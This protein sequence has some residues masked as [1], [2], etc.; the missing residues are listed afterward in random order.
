M[1]RLVGTRFEVDDFAV[2]AERIEAYA[3]ATGD[4][5]PAY[6]GPE[7]VAPPVFGIVPVWGG[8]QSAMADPRLEIDLG[9]IVHGEQHMRYRRPI[10]A[11][12]VL[13]ST[14][15]LI[16]VHERGENEILVLRFSTADA[17]GEPV[18]EQD[19]VTVSRGTASGE[20]GRSTGATP[21]PQLPSPPDGDPD[22]ARTA[23]LDDEITYRYAKASGDDNRIHVDPEFARGAGLPGIIVQ[24]L[25]LLSI[26]LQG[27]IE[28]HASGDPGRVRA[29]GVRFS[30]P[31]EP[32]RG[33][34]TRIWTVPEGARFE[35]VDPDGNAVLKNGVVEIA[36]A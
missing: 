6:R 9:R 10:R 14:G 8:V 36:P 24:G 21:P 20:E 11:G 26:A 35:G 4:P 29:L 27:P 12:D 25:C 17:A 2:T 34:T 15:E 18:L 7:A 32:G 19:I 28:R 16:S 31:I 13:R 23:D 33:L 3:E 1:N 5:L 22:E 30:R